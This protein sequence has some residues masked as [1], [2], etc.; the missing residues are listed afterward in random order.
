MVTLNTSD[1]S[2]LRP[3][4]HAMKLMPWNQACVVC[5]L[6]S[7]CFLLLSGISLIFNIRFIRIRG[8][9]NH[10]V[11]SLILASLLVVT[12][13]M[14][15][16][17]I[18]LFTCYRHCLRIYCRL[19]GFISYLS[20]C[21]CILV[22]M[23]LS[24]HRYLSLCSWQRW[25]TYRYSNCFC[26]LFSVAFTLPIAF[27][28]LNSYSPEGIGFHCSLNW[29][30]Q[31][32]TSRFYIAASFFILYFFPLIL[33]TFFNL[34]V[35]CILRKAYTYHFPADSFKSDSALS[36]MSITSRRTPFSEQVQDSQ[37]FILQ[38]K[39]RKRSQMD[40]QFL[41]AMIV[42]IGYFMMAWTPYSIIAVAQVHQMNWIFEHAY[43][44]TISALIGKVSVILTPLIYLRI[45]NQTVFR[46]IL[47]Q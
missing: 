29:L 20:G 26:W 36:S 8:C 12:I 10:L 45:M 2:Y 42:L 4:L 27:D 13:S 34:R 7:L 23:M 44:M 18:Q 9:R 28:Y 6:I 30:D 21:L 16:I 46:K 24:I 31:S 35:H 37:Y 15:G 22:F 1:S 47:H 3:C 38:A 5:R 41:R 19:E 25:F 33:L 39:H 11:F 32:M 14:P 17:L 40:S 43:L